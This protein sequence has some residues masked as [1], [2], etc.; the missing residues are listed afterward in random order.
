LEVL[1]DGTQAKPYVHVKDCVAG[2]LYAFQHSSHQVN[3]FNLST[4]DTVAVNEIA[5]MVTEAMGLSGVRLSY[6]GGERG[7]PGDVPQVRLDTARLKALGWEPE[8]T[9][10]EAV[11][12]AI[13]E[14][15]G[16]TQ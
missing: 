14:I 10:K 16:A 1:G 15:S 5:R 4:A 6:T 7:W 3:V 9:S 2:M 8:H 12:R 13:D 11:R